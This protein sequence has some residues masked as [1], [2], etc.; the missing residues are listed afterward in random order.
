EADELGPIVKGPLVLEDLNSFVGLVSGTKM[1]GDWVAHM[2]DHPEDVYWDPDTGLPDTW[3][4]G[5]LTD[6]IAQAYGFP[7]AHDTGAQR[8]AWLDN[9]VSNWIGDFGFVQR[10]SVR[11]SEPVLVSDTT[12]CHGAVVSKSIEGTEA[13]VALRLWCV[14]QRGAVTA[15]GSAEVLLPSRR[16]D[17]PAPLFSEPKAT[18]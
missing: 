14:N 18:E 9:L 5:L 17:I 10:L 15:T 12:W 11:L 16:L 3:Q 6:K 2:R 13:R 1:Y 7:S 4:S 8:V